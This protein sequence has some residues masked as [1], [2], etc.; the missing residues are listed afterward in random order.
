MP[1]TLNVIDSV[2]QVT[3]RGG[4]L[5]SRD[6][7]TIILTDYDCVPNR[8][9]HQIE[10][11][12]PHWSAEVVQADISSAGFVIIFRKMSHKS[13]WQSSSFV[14]LFLLLLVLTCIL[15]HVHARSID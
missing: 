10:E 2:L 11:Q 7:N 13:T 4:R 5:I 9:L 12:C 1:S 6:E 8:V 14:Q 15:L 3:N